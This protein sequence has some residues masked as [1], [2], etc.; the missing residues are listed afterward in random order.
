MSPGLTAGTQGAE[1]LLPFKKAFIKSMMWLMCRL[2]KV[3]HAD[4]GAKRYI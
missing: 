3:H 4:Y 1:S 2:G